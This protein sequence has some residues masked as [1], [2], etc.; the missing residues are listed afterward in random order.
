MIHGAPAALSVHDLS[1]SFPARS[2]P[3]VDALGGVNLAVEPGSLVT[4]VGPSGCGKSTLLRIIAGLEQATAGVVR[5]NGNRVTTPQSDVGLVF[6]R[7]TLLPWRTVAEN[8]LLPAEVLHLDRAP[9][10][11]NAAALIALVGLAGFENRYPAQLSGGMQQRAAI[12]RSLA[13]DP[14]TLLLDEPFGALDALLREEMAL[15]LQRI[16]QLTAKTVLLV[17]HSI[18]EAVLLGDRVLVMTARPGRI[19]ADIGIDLPRPRTLDMIESAGFTHHA[20]RV[21]RALS[22]PANG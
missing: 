10:R 19:A 20:A 9:A 7:P 11:A 22:S 5:I 17:T 18:Q 8:V 14:P 15:E 16:W 1:K 2:A 3:P 13:H 4:V 12:A 6:Q 21:R